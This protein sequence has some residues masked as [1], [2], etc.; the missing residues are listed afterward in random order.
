[1]LTPDIRQSAR[2]FSFLPWR[3]LVSGADSCRA[4]HAP[5]L[6]VSV[7]SSF[8]SPD[9]M[10][11]ITS[12][13]ILAAAF[14]ALRASDAHAQAPELGRDLPFHVLALTTGATTMSVDPVN[15]ILTGAR[16]AGLSNDGI[17]YGATGYL[18][19]GRAMIGFDAAQ[20]TFGE[21][22]LN[23]GRTDD[24]NSVQVLLTTS[25]AVVSTGRIAVFPSLGVGFGKVNVAL[26][27]RA[28]GTG[29]TASQPTFAEIAADPGASSTLTGNHLLFSVGGGTDCLILRSRRDDV[30]VV[31]GLR[32][33][34]MLAPNRTTWTRGPQTVLAGPDA[35]AGG[36]FLRVVVGIG[37]R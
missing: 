27:D 20:T 34:Y 1:M 5:I 9:G 35:S 22:G 3:Q 8:T 16:F 26:R 14:L 15:A 33:G 30:G 12:L 28:G 13:R 18:S 36:P 19:L 23:N 2:R 31:F 11:H 4:R 32:A 25:Y 10:R 24:L 7:L 17:S 21:E 6:W 37:G 29:A